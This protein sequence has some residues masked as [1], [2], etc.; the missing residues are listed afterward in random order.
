MFNN[1][2]NKVATILK[3]CKSHFRNFC[4][5]FERYSGIKHCFDV[6]TSTA[7][8]KMFDGA[9]GKVDSISIN[10]FSTLYTL[11]DHNHLLENIRWLFETLS[12]NSGKNCIKVESNTAKW[13]QDAN[14]ENAFTVGEVLDMISFLVK[15]TY[16]KAF[17]HIFQQVKGMIMGG[18]VSGWLSDCSLM[19][20][21]F[22]YIRNKISNGLRVQANELKYFCRYRDDCT[23]LNCP[24]FLDIAKEMYPPSL[25]LTQENVDLSM[26]NVLDMEVK[27]VQRS[28]ITKIYCKTDHFPFN[29]ISLPFLES[30]ID[31]DLCYRVFY[32]QIIRFER[33]STHRTDFE[34]RTKFLG[35][36]LK[37]RGYLSH[38]LERQFS[39]CIIKYM[40]EFQKWELP[41][42]VKEWF[43]DIFNSQPTDLI[44]PQVISDSFSQPAVSNLSNNN[45]R[46]F[47]SQP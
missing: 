40:A 12:K 18:K 7:V 6:E 10:D 41:L 13:V 29:V 46:E 5:A 47:N 8:K 34:L 36:I 45:R 11:F 17:G 14:G 3:M 32:S 20:D 15:E 19:V 31:K 25:S 44:L 2:D 37:E 16:I 28:C 33:L 1:E 26:A 4:G 27:I 42:N 30:N 38:A 39:K 35:N 43:G 24:G 9:H 21:E 22:K 23:T